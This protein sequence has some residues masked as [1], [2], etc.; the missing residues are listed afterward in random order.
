MT[1]C[2]GVD[3]ELEFPGAAP[4]IEA[5]APENDVSLEMIVPEGGVDDYDKYDGP[6]EVI[7]RIAAQQ[8]QTAKKV[9][10][11]DLIVREIPIIA[12]ANA[13]GGNTVVIGD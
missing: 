10:T 2:E 9:M 13:A 5:T 12:V 6:Y 3:I 8:L 11:D 7:P 1:G 4:E